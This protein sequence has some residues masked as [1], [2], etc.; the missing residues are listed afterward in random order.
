MG[1]RR[2]TRAD[3]DLGARLLQAGAA[4]APRHAWWGTRPRR[5]GPGLGVL[6]QPGESPDAPV[7]VRAWVAVGADRGQ[8]HRAL[9]GGRLRTD[10]D[11]HGRDIK[12]PAENR[13]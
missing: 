4:T 1:A 10:L 2:R 6:E 7:G 13:R 8:Q 11:L 12:G 5:L 9:V 3:V